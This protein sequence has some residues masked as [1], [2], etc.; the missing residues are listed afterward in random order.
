MSRAYWVKLASS[1]STTIDASDKAIHKIDLEAVV[2]AGEMGE[3]LERALEQSGWTRSEDN[4]R[5]FS[6]TMQ[7]GVELTWNL[8]THT[9]EAAATEQRQVV[10]EVE[11]Q[12]RGYDQNIARSDAERQLAKR[13]KAAQQEASIEEERLQRELTDRLGANEKD[14]VRELN[15]V[16]QKTY[17]EAVKRKAGRLGNVTSVSESQQDGEYQLT[18]VIS[19]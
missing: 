7:D 18:I 19:E 6:K 12:G 4:G 5:E 11:V 15:E 2:P 10:R 14:R 17:A 1:V 16:L 13:E 8:D 3:L 9:V